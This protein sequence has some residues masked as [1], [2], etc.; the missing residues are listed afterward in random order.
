MCEGDFKSFNA[1]KKVIS[2]D[3][4]LSYMNEEDIFD[5]FPDIGNKI[6]SGAV[7]AMSYLHSKYIVHRDIKPANVYC[8]FPLY[9]LQTRRT[10]NGVS[11]KAY[12]HTLSQYPDGDC[13]THRGKCQIFKTFPGWDLVVNVPP[14]R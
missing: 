7:R 10:G 11:Q 5:S 2:L 4:F 6:V 13:L 14:R 8:Q 9:K 3:Q 1:D 12:C